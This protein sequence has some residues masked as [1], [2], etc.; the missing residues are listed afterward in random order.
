MRTGRA[1]DHLTAVFLDRDG[2]INRKAPEGSY[3][4]TL[5]EFVFLPGAV[6]G[7]RLLATLDVPLVV[8]TNQRGIAL[9]RMSETDVE[10]IHDHLTAEV[11][12]AGG[13]LDLILHCPHDRGT[14]ECRKPGTAMF[15]L[16][17]RSLPGVELDRS[18]M[19]GDSSV[20]MEA[21]RRIGAWAVLVGE[22]RSEEADLVVPDLLSAARAVAA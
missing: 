6:E 4:R 18:V 8:V 19:I 1:P 2:V 9:G 11:R 14:C 10:A 21:A 15:A 20:D 22:P 12:A 16:A 3:V 17:A 7:L 13:R 5:E